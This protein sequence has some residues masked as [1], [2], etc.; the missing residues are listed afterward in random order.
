MTKTHEWGT[1]PEMFGP[2]HAHRLARIVHE[3]ERLPPGS[4]ILDGAV[5]LGT[6]A[7]SM[8]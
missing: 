7:V 8:Q 6:L 3:V 5:G 1:Q 4:R 2:L